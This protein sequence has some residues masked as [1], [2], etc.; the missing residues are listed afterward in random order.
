MITGLCEDDIISVSRLSK[1]DIVVITGFKDDIV[2]ITGF[3][4]DVIVVTAT[5]VIKVSWHCKI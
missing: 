5:L 3:G 2:V 4:K 1:D